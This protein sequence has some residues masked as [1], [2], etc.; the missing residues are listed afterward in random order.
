MTDTPE[1]AEDAPRFE[2]AIVNLSEAVRSLEDDEL[3]LDESLDCYQKGIEYVKQCQ[4]LL[5]HAERKIELL[6]GFDAEGNPVTEPMD[7][8]SM[9]LA[10]KAEGRSRRRS[11]K[12]G[13]RSKVQRKPANRANMEPKSDAG[14]DAQTH[15]GP[16]SGDVGD[17]DLGGTLF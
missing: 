4:K 1:E 16:D 14:A 9:T 8:E 5:Q 12:A 3:T 11:A 7:D 13:K 17:V 15:P 10:E 6:S 2:D